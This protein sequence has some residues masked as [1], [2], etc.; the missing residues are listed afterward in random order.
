MRSTFAPGIRSASH[1]HPDLRWSQSAL[2]KATENTTD[3]AILPSSVT[4]ARLSRSASAA[5]VRP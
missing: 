3:S 2:A 4:S 5:L 1:L